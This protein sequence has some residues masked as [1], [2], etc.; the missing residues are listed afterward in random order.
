MKR[1][2]LLLM[3]LGLV[4][5]VSLP[6]EIPGTGLKIQSDYDIPDGAG[7]MTDDERIVAIVATEAMTL[8]EWEEYNKDYSE[9]GFTKT[10]SDGITYY[11]SCEIGEENDVVC[12]MDS[13]S[14]GLHYIIDVNI[15]DS[16]ESEV[17]NMGK[18]IGKQVIG[19]APPLIA[20]PPVT[21]PVEPP[22]T[23]P[24]DGKLC[25]FSMFAILAGL[26]I[27]TRS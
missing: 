14:G 19:Y 22:V 4:F 15:L 17:L 10:V 16:T 20:P 25:L 3:I 1:F 2:I 23:P 24:D 5:A 21:P 13:Y 18:A 9:Y 27:A 6:N 26:A 11:Y 12:L 8:A 7:Y